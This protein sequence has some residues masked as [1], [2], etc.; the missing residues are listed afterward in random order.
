A[1][2][3]G[4]PPDR[5]AARNVADGKRV[6]DKSHGPGGL[7]FGTANLPQRGSREEK[8]ISA[9]IAKL[10]EL[11][12]APVDVVVSEAMYQ[13]AAGDPITAE[14]AMNFLPAGNNPPEPQVTDTP[15]K[16]IALSHRVALF[17]DP[18]PAPAVDGW[19]RPT[20]RGSVDPFV[21]D[22]AERQLGDPTTVT[23]TIRY[24]VSGT[25]GAPQA[26]PTTT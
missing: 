21:E 15:T 17:L 25:R 20:P 6:R 12:D 1:P 4:P 22:W 13:I 8:A 3:P 10:D 18:P 7:P 26:A 16:G 5:T 11:M 9:E 14:A 2:E 19:T 23:A 24:Q